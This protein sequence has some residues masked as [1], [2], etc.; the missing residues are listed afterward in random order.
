MTNSHDTERFKQVPGPD[1]ADNSRSQRDPA[2]PTATAPDSVESS[3]YEE[4][5]F[6]GKENAPDPNAA[7]EPMAAGKTSAESVDRPGPDEE[8]DNQVGPG[9][10]LDPDE[11][12]DLMETQ[13]EA[14]RI[15]QTRDDQADEDIITLDSP[16]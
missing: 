4:A 12:A 8:P 13:E 7:D 11:A 1:D 3:V 14:K 6:A 9:A 2:H 15:K 10:D 16:G 5:E